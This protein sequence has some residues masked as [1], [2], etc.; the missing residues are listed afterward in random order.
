LGDR[1]IHAI[2][3][4]RLEIVWL[5]LDDEADENQQKITAGRHRRLPVCQGDLDNV[6]GLISV[7]VLLE[8]SLA[9]QPL[10]LTVGLEQ[11]LV[12][13]EYGRALPLLEE[14]KKSRIHTALVVDE[15]GLIQ[16]L[17]TLGD[18]LEALVGDVPSP[19]EMGDEVVK[20][21]DGSWL[22]GGS[23]DV[24]EVYSVLGLAAALEKQ[25]SYHTLGGLVIHQLGRIP[26][27]GDRFDW[28][29][30]EIEVMDMDSNRVDK[31]LVTPNRPDPDER[32]DCG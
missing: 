26:K 12:V 8:R 27:A 4:P 14:F 7:N 23:M 28:Q 13:P 2:M 29:G 9:H 3:T 25:P 5:D 21:D 18:I 10:D 24:N 1:P 11:P 19:H 15:Y 22:L 16:G 30:F 6:L 20:R 17:V 32:E 31:L